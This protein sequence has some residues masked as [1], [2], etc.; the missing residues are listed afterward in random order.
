[1][2]FVRSSAIAAVLLLLLPDVA[3]ANENAAAGVA[4]SLTVPEVCQLTASD[5]VLSPSSTQATASIFEMCNGAGGFRIIASYRHLAAGEAIRVNYGGAITQLNAVG[6]SEVA[7]RA[8]PFVGAQRVAIQS[9][10][11]NDTLSISFGMTPL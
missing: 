9:S 5:I 4:I 10:N 3:Q 6:I 2:R 8:G 11:L 7:L 1:M